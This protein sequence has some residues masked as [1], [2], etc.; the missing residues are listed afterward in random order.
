M[1]ISPNELRRKVLEMVYNK[2]SGHIGGS[3]SLAELVAVLYSDYDIGGMDRLILSK[4]HSVPI[5]FSVLHELGKLSDEELNTFREVNSRLQGHPDKVRLPLM[6]ATTGSLGQGLSIAA[7]HALAK[8]LKKENGTIFCILGDGE[9]GEGQIWEALM[10]FPK[11]KLTNLICIVDWNKI[12]SDGFCKDFVP[13]YDNLEERISS[14]GWDCSVVDGHNMKTIRTYINGAHLNTTVPVCLI[15]N[16][17][18]G[19]GVSF[20]ENDPSWHSRVP[21]DEEYRKALKELGF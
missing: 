5:I 9:L 3:F 19:K 17:V 8:N 6:D 18:K 7:G 1:E 10:L 13:M 21:T 16:T 14:F 4:G 15:L 20:M 2:K 12:Q 11:F